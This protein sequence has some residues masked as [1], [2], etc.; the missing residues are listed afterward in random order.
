[1]LLH[2]KYERRGAGPYRLR[3]CAT[4][5]GG[6]ESNSARNKKCGEHNKGIEAARGAGRRKRVCRRAGG[7]EQRLHGV[8]VLGAIEAM[9]NDA[10]RIRRDLPSPRDSRRA[11]GSGAS[12][13]DAE[14]TG[15]TSRC[16][17]RGEAIAA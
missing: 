5:G 11:S 13:G 8:V 7:A 15:R 4:V 14:S 17:A 6:S 2:T 3:G 9:Q 1:M 10:A 16:G 12:H